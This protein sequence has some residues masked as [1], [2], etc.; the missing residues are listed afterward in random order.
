M[1]YPKLSEL[2]WQMLHKIDQCDSKILP[3]KYSYWEKK[4]LQA[5]LIW[6]SE[7]WPFWIQNFR[8]SWP[9]LW[10]L[11]FV[12]LHCVSTKKFCTL[13]VCDVISLVNTWMGSICSIQPHILQS[14]FPFWNMIMDIILIIWKEPLKRDYKNETKKTVTCAKCM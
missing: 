7:T 13:T 11:K 6:D 12:V 4:T 9:L 5:H 14:R 1:N 10:C 3:Q 2:I 8:H